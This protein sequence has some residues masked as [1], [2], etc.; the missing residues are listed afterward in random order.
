MIENPKYTPMNDESARKKLQE[1]SYYYPPTTEGLDLRMLV[2]R[3]TRGFI[4][5]DSC[6][7][8]ELKTFTVDR[9]LPLPVLKE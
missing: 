7:M 9:G 1:L 4:S 5:Y 3:A 8:D 6:T 2:L